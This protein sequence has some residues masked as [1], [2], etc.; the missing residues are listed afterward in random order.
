MK[1]ILTVVS[2]GTGDPE[3]LNGKTVS[4]IRETGCLV[5]R[6][7]R[8]PL[9]AWLDMEG[10]PYSSLDTFYEQADDFDALNAQ[11]CAHLLSLASATDLVYAVTD[12]LTDRTVRG[13]LTA[14]AQDISLHVIPGTGLGDIHLSAA[15]SLLP[16]QPVLAASACD[17]LDGF[18]WDPN[19][20]LLVTE[21]NDPILAGEIKILISRVLEDE[22]TVYLIRGA[23]PPQPVPL[24]MIDRL[25]GTDHFTAV[26]IPASGLMDRS[27]FSIS[28]LSALMDRLRAPDGC[29][30]DGVQTHESLR[31]YLV[32]EAWECVAAIDQDDP[33]HL[34]EELGDLLFQVIFHSSI[35]K[36]FDEF[37]LDD[38]ITAVT[39]KMIRRHPHVF[40]DRILPD[41]GSVRAAWEKIKQEETG[42]TTVSGSLDDVSSGLPSLKYAAKTFKKLDQAPACRRPSEMILSEIR[43]LTGTLES[44]APN[45]ESLSRL[46]L[47]C[48]EL[49]YR[50]GFDSELILHRA[51]DRL[52]N[53][54]K[55]AEKQIIRDGKSLEHLTFRELG[56]YL[57]YVEGEIE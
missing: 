3:L 15:L 10:I 24:Y 14:G 2:I 43:D 57:Q 18:P 35:G 50:S 22:H 48:T 27:R 41:S 7:A 46:L 5:L 52:R 39:G 23:S 11:I 56:V 4:A 21:L 30:W 20:S 8:H 6:T 25:F 54:I 40:G 17:L 37:T 28:D 33:D 34:C 13:L 38:V 16:D 9:A 32:E 36:T 26:F 42:R 55:A 29:P 19:H 51:A 12:A 49:C 1:H 45:E 31:P 47:L 44:V 53:R